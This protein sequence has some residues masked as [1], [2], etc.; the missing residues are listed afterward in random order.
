[1]GGKKNIDL[2][3]GDSPPDLVVE[4]DLTNP[5]LSKLPIYAHLGVA[6]VWLFAVESRRSSL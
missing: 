5:S 1:M 2:D 6:E 4:V 3:A